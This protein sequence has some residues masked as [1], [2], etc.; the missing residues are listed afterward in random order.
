MFYSG[1]LISGAFSGLIAAGIR[2][3]LDGAR[4]LRAWRWLFIIEGSITVVIAFAS[5]FMLPN[6]PRTTKWLSEEER[7]L[8][9]WRLEEDIGQDDWVDSRDQSFKHGL[10]LAF[11]DIKTYVL[12]VLIFGIVASGSVTNFFP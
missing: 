8:A 3:H 6:F 10:K 12:T 1:S 4:G 7:S 2:A 5:Y 11:L 9:V